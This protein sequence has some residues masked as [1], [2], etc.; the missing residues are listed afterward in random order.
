M[1]KKKEV[2]YRYKKKIGLIL[3]NF[4]SMTENAKQILKLHK[5]TLRFSHESHKKTIKRVHHGKELDVSHT[6]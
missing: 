3:K 5:H 4:G 2:K 1:I 6:L